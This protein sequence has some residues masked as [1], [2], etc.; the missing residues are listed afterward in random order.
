MRGMSLMDT[1]VGIFLLLLVFVGIS[2]VF[3]LSIEVVSNNKARIGGLALAQER[4]E[5]IRSLS[6]DHVGTSGGIPS[7]TITQIEQVPLNGVTYTR[8]TLISYIDDPADGEGVADENGV[9]TDAKEIKVEVSWDSHGGLRDVVLV[10]RMSPIGIEQ[11]VPG[12]TLAIYVVDAAAA[13]LPGA[14]VTVLNDSTGVNTQAYSNDDGL[15]RFFGA[16]EGTGYEI[17]VS[18][19]GYSTEQTYDA[20]TENPSPNPGHLTVQLYQTTSSTF[21]IDVTGSYNVRTYEAVKTSTWSDPFD[22]SS[23]ISTSASTTVAAG[24][25]QLEVG[26]I[27]GYAVSVAIAPVYLAGWKELRVVDTLPTGATTHYYVYGDSGSGQV[28]I[29]E[30]QLPGN[31]AGFTT[32][33]VDLTGIATSTYSALWL[34]AELSTD[35]PDQAPT[36]TLWEVD[37]DEGPL[38]LPDIPFSLRGEKTIGSNVGVEVYKFDEVFNSGADAATTVSDVEWDTYTISVDGA[39]GYDIASMCAPMPH[40][41]APGEDVD[42]ALYFKEHTTHSLR[43]VVEDESGDVIPEATVEVSR[44]GYDE[45]TASDGCGQAFFGGM[46]SGTILAGNTYTVDVTASG[47]AAQSVANVEVNGA[48]T[49]TIVLAP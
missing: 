47:Y 45:T 1:L 23:K 12:G 16:P 46:G 31:S 13:P 3:Q 43:V 10:S 30:V 8:R 26:E 39:T 6:Y 35:D 42:V 44:T 17:V 38:P 36:V 40:S 20:D 14:L 18:K 4:M 9:V 24:A 48:S 29:P 11:L 2:G 34:R 19:D 33:P 49:V 27:E 37:Y 41:L 22:G 28:L 32:F 15:V 25:L 7:G 5:Y 21:A